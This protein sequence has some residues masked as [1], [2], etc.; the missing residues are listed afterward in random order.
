[1]RSMLFS[2]CS[3]ECELVGV[4][5]SGDKFANKALIVMSECFT[6]PPRLTLYMSPRLTF[7]FE[8][9]IENP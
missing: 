3:V 1:M 2:R 8:I 7:R 5:H 9:A 6:L 4:K